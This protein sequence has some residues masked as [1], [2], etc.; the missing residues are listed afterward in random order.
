MK[1]RGLASP[2]HGDALCLTFAK[3]VVAKIRKKHQQRK[4]ELFRG[5]GKDR[6]QDPL[7]WTH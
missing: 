7:S 3:D 4:R 1:K 2:D 5:R 6:P